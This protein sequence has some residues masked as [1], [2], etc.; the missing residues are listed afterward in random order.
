MRKNLLRIAL[1]TPISLMLFLVTARNA[2]GQF[3][4]TAWYN[5]VA[6]HSGKCLAVAGGNSFVQNG[7]DVIQWTCIASEDNQKWRVVPLNDGNYQIIAKHSGR[8][9]EVRGGV[10]ARNNGAPV[11]QSDYLNAANQ[12]WKIVPLGDGSCK[13]VAA[14]SRLSLDVNGGPG[15]IGDG[16]FVQQWEY[17]GGQNQ[18]WKFSAVGVNTATT[19]L[20]PSPSQGHFRVTLVAFAVNNATVDNL[21]QIDGAGDEVYA[22][23]DYAEIWSPR[24]LVGV[25]QHQSL[26]YGDTSATGNSLPG[27]VQVGRASRTGGLI[28]LDRV[29][30]GGEQPPFP[31]NSTR[32]DRARM[33]PMVIWD[34]W[35][36]RD[37]PR[38]N[39]IV[40]VPTIWESDK[41]PD[42]RDLWNQRIPEF[43]R[44]FAL[45]SERFLDGSAT[46]QL[47]E[48]TAVVLRTVPQRNDFD[49][50]VGMD[51]SIFTLFSDV[52]ATFIPAVMLLTFDSAQNAANSTAQG[53]GVVEI[54][55][56]DGTNYGPGNYTMFLLVERL[57]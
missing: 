11:Q 14:H 6:L 23:V 8:S 46:R 51:G 1:L 53:R 52:P 7:V 35:L 47:V 32:A 28:T 44:Q 17:W 37:G 21:L 27:T 4:P 56:H 33:L 49:R 16:P 54:S 45:T 41:V 29:G 25:Q 34:G 48:R 31:A 20:P 9:L 5:I 13:I 3:D 22:L 2:Y 12:K 18:K 55:Y 38:R 57:P 26:L 30:L 36:V 15:A 40:I 42:V 24:T 50:P 10:D 43:F 19:T 39:E